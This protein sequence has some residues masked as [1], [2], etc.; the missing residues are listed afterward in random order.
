MAV[1]T[2]VTQEG[3]PDTG[4]SLEKTPAPPTPPAPPAPAAK[5]GGKR[6]VPIYQVTRMPK[7]K[8]PVSP[9]IPDAFR[10]AEREALVV[11]EVELDVH[12]HVQNARV[13]RHAEFG[14][15]DAALA[16][17]KLT[18]FEPALVGDEA[19]PVRYQIPYRFKVH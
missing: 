18:E 11:V 7:A 12:G 1:S 19:V 17:A 9:E 10:Q 15:D 5:P 2:G 16:A 14:L 3:Q 8:A 6:F 4:S 13:V